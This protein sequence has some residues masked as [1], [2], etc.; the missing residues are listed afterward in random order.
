[1]NNPCPLFNWTMPDAWFD[2]TGAEFRTWVRNYIPFCFT[3][4]IFRTHVN[5][6]FICKTG[7]IGVSLWQRDK[8]SGRSLDFVG[9]EFP[10]NRTSVSHNVMW[11]QE[12]RTAVS[13]NVMWPQE[14]RTSVSHNV[15]W[16]QE[17]KTSVS[18]NV[19]W[20]QENRTSVSH[21]VIWPPDSGRQR[22]VW[23]VI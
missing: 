7:P 3:L 13:H 16:P 1:M 5:L 14:N 22:D 20:P 10:W 9:Q 15:M 12:K 19:M 23:Y 6:S 21:N 11:P 2:E 4:T 18:H 17:N 8:N